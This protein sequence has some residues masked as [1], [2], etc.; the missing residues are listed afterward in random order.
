VT[1][2]LSYFTRRTILRQVVDA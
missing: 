1:D 2:I